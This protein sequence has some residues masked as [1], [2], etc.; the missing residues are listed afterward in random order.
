MWAETKRD[1]HVVMEVMGVDTE[2]IAVEDIAVLL[3]GT[4]EDAH[5][6]GLVHLAGDLHTLDLLLHVGDHLQDLLV[7]LAHRLYAEDQDL[8]LNRLVETGKD[9]DIKSP[10]FSFT[11]YSLTSKS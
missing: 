5:H 11:P 2:D 8:A 7:D 1:L 6:L 3:Q 9:P 4:V 10:P